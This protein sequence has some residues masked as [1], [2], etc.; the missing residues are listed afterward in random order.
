MDWNIT[1]PI[2]S[3]RFSWLHVWTCG[4][5]L[6]MLILWTIIGNVFVVAAIILEKNL[7]SV[8]NYLILSLAVADL[9]V[10]VLVMPIS[11]INE[12]SSSWWMGM[13]LCDIWIFFDVLCCTAS[14]LHLVAIAIDRYWAVTQI[15]FIR[16]KS[17]ARKQI[18]IM[19]FCVW[20]VSIV[21]SIPSRFHGHR[22]QFLTSEDGVC[23]MNTNHT[24]IIVANIGAF[25]LP[26]LIMVAI[27]IR[28]YVFAK[29]QIR[30]RS[31]KFRP[32]DIH[33]LSNLNPKSTRTGKENKIVY[34]SSILFRCISVKTNTKNNQ[35]QLV[36]KD[37]NHDNNVIK[38]SELDKVKGGKDIEHIGDYIM[39]PNNISKRQIS[40]MSFGSQLSDI[41]YVDE[42]EVIKH[43]SSLSKKNSPQPS[44][45][46]SP[47][48][49]SI[50]TAI[51][52]QAN[53]NINNNIVT[54]SG[55]SSTQTMIA[56]QFHRYSSDDTNEIRSPSV[57]CR[58][59]NSGTDFQV[60]SESVFESNNSTKHGSQELFCENCINALDSELESSGFPISSTELEEHLACA[61]EISSDHV[62]SYG[63]QDDIVARSISSREEKISLRVNA[64]AHM[65]TKEP[66]CRQSLA[67]NKNRLSNAMW[68]QLKIR[69]RI[70]IEQRRERKAARTLAIIT[71]CFL[72]C[73]LPFATQN[74]INLISDSPNNTNHTSY[75]AL[76]IDSF[77][78]WLGYTNS[79][80]N[81][82]IYTVFSPDFRR[83]FRKIL[84]GR[85]YHRGKRSQ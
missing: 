44:K 8:S 53:N 13:S 27:Y 61:N 37:A 60:D 52:K 55:E 14:V 30:K 72:I 56:S 17:G 73:W 9:M 76:L 6:V 48:C 49:S 12:I 1:V 21:I 11:V 64:N 63:H 46:S 74:M 50:V 67:K 40:L 35:D 38:D 18:L 70:K 34:F 5:I 59:S 33:T 22:N 79:C 66:A 83:S 51:E 78:L 77:I 16:K 10:A 19:I 31:T 71:G 58:S 25:F 39:N 81:P 75:K 20:S 57:S 68:H 43:D 4:P 62:I 54:I 28:I 84:F 7:Q 23:R 80:L 32:P 2:F 26:M 15:N 24:Y 29:R 41:P 42:D 82:I 36:F 65:C 69:S 47:S 3:P 85:Y 45:L